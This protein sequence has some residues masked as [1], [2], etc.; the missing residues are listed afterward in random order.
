M[1]IDY[2]FIAAPYVDLSR[3]DADCE[4]LQR[5]LDDP[6]P[7]DVV[8]CVSVGRKASGEVR[9][10]REHGR[11]R[12]PELAASPSWSLAAGLALAL[13]PSI[14]GD[15]PASQVVEREMLGAVAGV[16]AGALGRAALHE[17]GLSL[18]SFPAGL[19]V[20]TTP[21]GEQRVC[22]ALTNAQSSMSRRASVDVEAIEW[23]VEL[24]AAR[25]RPHGAR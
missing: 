4:V 24:I 14:A 16:V 15:I 6:A 5:L 22:P 20:T 3:V 18:D 9:F 21:A 1:T 8:D 19:I 23:A 13:F 10:H 12:S 25:H 11:D 7:P 17:L 2:I